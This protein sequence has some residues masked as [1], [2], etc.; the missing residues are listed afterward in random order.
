MGLVIVPLCRGKAVV[1][2]YTCG[3]ANMVWIFDGDGGGGAIAEQ[4]RIDGI[5][6]RLFGLG[7][8]VVT[9]CADG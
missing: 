4:V 6:E 9:D 8:D 2:K 1:P 5:A 3:D 7:F